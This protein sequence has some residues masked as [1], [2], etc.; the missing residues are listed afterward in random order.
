[1]PWLEL[2][3]MEQRLE[4]M[5]AFEQGKTANEVA[6]RYGVSRKTFS[7][8]RA[9][10]KQEGAAGLSDKSRRP[11]RSP[12]RTS[13]ARV[14]R[15]LRLKKK[16]PAWGPQKLKKWAGV[17]VS[18]VHRIL[19]AAGWVKP[20][21]RRQKTAEYVG[22]LSE[23]NSPN[24]VWSIDFKGQFRM[25]NGAMCYPLTVTD[26]A[27]RFI[28]GIVAMR[29]TEAL[30]V[31]HAM[32][33]LFR[34][35]GLP[36]AIRS[37]NGNP[38]AAGSGPRLSHLS[39]CWEAMGIVHERIEPGVPQQNGRHERMHRTM[40][41]EMDGAAEDLQRQQ[42]WFD[43]FR[44]RFNEVRPHE[45][46]AEKTPASRYRPSRRRPAPIP[47]RFKPPPGWAERKVG[48]N[49]RVRFRKERPFISKTLVGQR[50]HLDDE[51]Q[52]GVWVNG[53]RLGR[54]TTDGRLMD[55]SPMS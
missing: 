31:K 33:K 47:I 41:D 51:I 17:S 35:Y 48:L 46:L 25:K 16:Y 42:R 49:G 5:R 20:R 13:Q 23:A 55:L 2:T 54:L 53:V 22:V 1:M 27:S 15:L 45:A 7:K 40:A 37:D 26:N 43:A 39:R 36:K 18:T 38:F 19:K 32:E 44:K 4:M 6:R 29:S 50:I 3:R 10:Y 28:L 14:E 34:R 52:P 11:K 9:R 8:W 21:R 24:D 30:P 12:K